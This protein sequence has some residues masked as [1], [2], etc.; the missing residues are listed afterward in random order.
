QQKAGTYCSL[1]DLAAARRV[2]R[3]ALQR[4]VDTTALVAR[5][6]LFQEMMW[7]LD[8]DLRSRV[9]RLTPANF[10]GD[11]GHWGLKVGGTYRLMGDTV[12]ARADGDSARLA[13]A[14]QLRAFPD[15]AQLHELLG[16]ALALGGHRA[17]AVREAELSLRLRET[18]L[19]AS[20]G[21]YVRYQVARIYIQ[22]G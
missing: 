13:F 19:D 9:L 8:D 2:I 3:E 16:R 5:F 12:H 22:A 20:T 1:G 15:N 6:S 18:Q 10:D 11:R 14:E 7:V 21:P 17:E 4:G